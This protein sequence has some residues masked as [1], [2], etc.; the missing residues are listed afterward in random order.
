[1]QMR[2]VKLDLIRSRQ[3]FSVRA[4]T[5]LSRVSISVTQLI[6]CL[7]IGPD[8]SPLHHVCPSLMSS[9]CLLHR[10]GSASGARF[11]AKYGEQP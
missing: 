5:D 3:F 6:R 1:M 8:V 4:W 2:K 9:T 10:L 11:D 7:Y